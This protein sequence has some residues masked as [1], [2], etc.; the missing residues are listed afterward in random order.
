MAAWSTTLESEVLEA[1]ATAAA[2]GGRRRGLGFWAFGGGNGLKR[3]KTNSNK[4]LHFE[5][6]N[7]CLPR[8][9]SDLHLSH[10]D[11][12]N[13]YCISLSAAP[14]RRAPQRQSPQGHAVEMLRRPAPSE[15]LGCRR[16]EQ[17]A[18]R[19]AVKERG[20]ARGALA[21]QSAPASLSLLP[22]SGEEDGDQR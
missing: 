15:E 18:A 22:R 17:C 5:E 8:I 2:S 10:R 1:I 4:V 3:I 11:V 20:G 6:A 14:H 7:P 16:D 19:R 13:S 12:S 9:H 21:S